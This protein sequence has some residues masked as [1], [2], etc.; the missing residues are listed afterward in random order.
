VTHGLWSAAV[1]V[2]QAGDRA[3]PHHIAA[4]SLDVI[5]PSGVTGPLFQEIPSAPTTNL[6]ADLPPRKPRF[7]GS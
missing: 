6:L 3:D 4:G 1:T 7:V 5:V 2:G